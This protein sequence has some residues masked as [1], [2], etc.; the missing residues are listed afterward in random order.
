M[1]EPLRQLDSQRAEKE[2][3]L[4]SHALWSDIHGV[5]ILG[6]SGSLEK[7]NAGSTAAIAESLVS[8]C[9]AGYTR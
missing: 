5:C 8:N 1:E 2:V 7:A 9:L 6:L 3:R 4:A